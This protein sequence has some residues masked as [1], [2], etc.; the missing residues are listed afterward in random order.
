MTNNEI[1]VQEEISFE[2]WM[3]RVKVLLTLLDV[4]VYIDSGHIDWEDLY[5]HGVKPG[6]VWERVAAAVG[7]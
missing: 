5:R 2:D 3:D 6:R 4:A 7:H 1:G